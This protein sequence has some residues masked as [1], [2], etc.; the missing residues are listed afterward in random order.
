MAWCER[1]AYLE[2]ARLGSREDAP[3]EWG[4]VCGLCR[5]E[6]ASIAELDERTEHDRR[7][8]A[9]EQNERVTK[10]SRRYSYRRGKNYWL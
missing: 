2:R 3:A 9:P 4:T 1:C 7:L 5:A 6:L 10:A 8:A